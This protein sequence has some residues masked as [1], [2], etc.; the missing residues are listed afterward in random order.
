MLKDSVQSGSEDSPELF[1]GVI[2]NA[3][4][5]VRSAIDA[6]RNFLFSTQ[7]EDGYWCG[8]LEADTTLES[9]YILLHTLLGT[10][11]EKR[12]AKA[13]REILR[14]QNEDG[15]WP[16]YHGGPSNIS[17]SVKAYFG[18]KLAGFTADHPALA[19]AR[20]KILDLGGVTEVNTFTKIYLCFFGQY[21][22]E[23]VPAIPPEIV[24]FPRWFW[25][26]IYEIS[27]WSR[28]ILVPLSIAYAKKPFK[29]IP[30]E[31]GIDELF[32]GGR[33]NADLHLKWAKK[34]VSWRNFFLVL[35]HMTH[36]FERVHIRPLRSL[37][38]KQAEKW[39][40]ERFEMSD[41]LGA[42]YPAMMNAIIALRCLGYSLDDPQVIRAID[43]FEKLGIEEADT[44]RMQPCMSPV[45]DTAYALFALGEADNGPS[46]L[47][48]D[49]RLVRS[50]EWMLKK[51]VTHK[52]DWAVK[53]RNV[54]P[55]GWYFEFNNEFYPD[56]D[57]SAMVMLGLSKVTTSNERYQHESV[58]RAIDWVLAMQC[59][60]GGWASFD[61]D[62]DKMVFQYVPF[63]DHNAMLDP[64]TVD[65]TG[66]VV[67]MLAAHGFTQKDRCIQRAL[68][69]IRREQEPD[70]SWFGR[71]G[72]NYIY[73]TMQVLRGLDAIGIDH[74]EPMVQQA[75]EWL[76]MF[77]NSDG[78]WGET[79]NSYDDPDTRGI[80]PSTPS[81]TAWAV[82]GLLAAGD[83]RSEAVQKGVA[84]LLKTQRKDGSWAEPEYTGTGFPRVFY[85]AYHLY[86]IYFP[87]MALTGYERAFGKAPLR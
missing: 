68:E 79:C 83:T 3:A 65:I 46:A 23:A 9:D 74:N 33:E 30:D 41:G 19:R 24:L 54:A 40:L 36:W 21:S 5:K 55:G 51:Q 44:F 13:A 20:K 32:L 27:S 61:K 8:E 56:V 84:Y 59:R 43:E 38:L 86:R 69:F 77:Q 39:L 7:H 75:A 73:G 76:R 53:V 57:D 18:L 52:G 25:F 12:N 4:A 42:I 14:H 1:F 29:K 67:E 31:M 58:K 81:Q 10:V 11:D 22:Y 6:T 26:N 63:A 48:S 66:R 49:P 72:V 87:L 71:W 37:A 50:A 47:S 16:I 70:G 80:G 2:D 35:N 62:N 45:W 60:D 15:G 82:L 17:A 34:P 28:A 85:L 64:P 78:G